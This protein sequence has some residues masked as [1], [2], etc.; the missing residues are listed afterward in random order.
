VRQDIMKQWKFTLIQIKSVT[1]QSLI[2]FGSRLI[3]QTRMDNS[4]IVEASTRQQSFIQHRNKERL[5]KPPK[6]NL[7]RAGNFINQLL[8]KSFQQEIF[9][10]LKL[11][12][13]TFIKRKKK[14]MRKI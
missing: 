14:P 10:L 1:G 4:M 6:R 3:R 12:I 7:L 2:Y 11:T 8:R 9:I 13:R 5:Q